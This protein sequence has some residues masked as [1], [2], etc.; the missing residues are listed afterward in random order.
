MEQQPLT[1][2]KAIDG[3]RQLTPA[4]HHPRAV[5]LRCDPGD[6]FPGARAAAGA[7]P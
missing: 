4:L 3:I 5:G 6:R 1:R 7:S 2:E